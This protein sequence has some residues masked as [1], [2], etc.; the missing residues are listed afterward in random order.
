MSSVVRWSRFTFNVTAWLFVV[1]VVYQVYLAGQGVFQTG[2]FV[3]HREFGYL[4]GLLTLVLIVLAALGRTGWRVI[5][6]SALLLGLFALQ[7]VFVAF[8]APAPRSRRSTR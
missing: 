4:F 8:G 6:T 5:G 1:C 7:S 2:S 3:P